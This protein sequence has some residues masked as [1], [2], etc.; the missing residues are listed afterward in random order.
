MGL[1]TYTTNYDKYSKENKL[2]PHECRLSDLSYSAD[3]L[4]DIKYHLDGN[5]ERRTDVK[6]GRMPIMLG[7]SHCR[8]SGK[9]EDELAFL[10]ECPYDPRGYFIINGSEKV[11]LIQ[12]QMIEN[13]IIV[14]KNV[15]QD[16]IIAGVV[17]YTLDTKSVCGVLFKD[18]RLYL[19]SGSFQ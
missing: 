14:E 12:E 1:P 16:T 8:L 10:K 15:K 11:L 9:S 13:R 18:G 19:K 7:S 4:V 2:F 5:T 17:S 3:I 6:I